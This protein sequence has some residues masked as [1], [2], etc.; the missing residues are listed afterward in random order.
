M[1]RISQLIFVKINFVWKLF[2]FNTFTYISELNTNIYEVN[3][4]F[5]ANLYVD[6]QTSN[7]KFQLESILE[8]ILIVLQKNINYIKI[9]FTL[10]KLILVVLNVEPN[11]G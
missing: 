11:I 10:S 3:N 2:M 9:N 4:K 8:V 5:Y 1:K 6:L 7:L